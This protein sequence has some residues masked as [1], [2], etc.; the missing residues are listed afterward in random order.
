VGPVVLDVG[1]LATY[2]DPTVQTATQ[3]RYALQLIVGASTQILGE[4]TVLTPGL[5]RHQLGLAGAEPNPTTTNKLR[6][7]FTLP[8]DGQAEVRLYDITGRPLRS[9][10]YSGRGLH[11]VD[12]G[13]E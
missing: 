7:K 10:T 9:R 3:Y 11:Y 13:Q 6:V 8:D 5:E 12:F 2:S 4:R 1:H